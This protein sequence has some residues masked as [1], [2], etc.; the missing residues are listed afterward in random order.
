MIHFGPQTCNGFQKLTGSYHFSLSFLLNDTPTSHGL[1]QKNFMVFHP[2]FNYS[3][4]TD[5]SNAYGISQI[6]MAFLKISSTKPKKSQG[7]NYNCLPADKPAFATS[8]LSVRR[9]SDL[10][11][12]RKIGLRNHRT[13]GAR[14]IF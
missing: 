8:L 1:C 13:A 9:N 11:Y 6:R 14:V 10:S 5:F 2:I 3:Q 4:V 12:W 7:F